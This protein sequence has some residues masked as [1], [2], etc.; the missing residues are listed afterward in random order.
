MLLN[1]ANGPS[2]RVKTDSSF[3]LCSS[4]PVGAG[5]S[6]MSITSVSH[7]SLSVVALSN[8]TLTA[9]AVIY[10]PVRLEGGILGDHIWDLDNSCDL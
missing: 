4:A 3:R 5:R 10:F 6:P 7:L 8:Q 1:R 9:L 2:N